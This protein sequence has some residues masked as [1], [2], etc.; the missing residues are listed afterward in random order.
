MRALLVLKLSGDA[1]KFYLLVVP[2]SGS[3]KPAP[4]LEAD[5]PDR[6]CAVKRE[7]T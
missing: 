2:A 1:I 5:I 3:K 7:F 6:T 4:T